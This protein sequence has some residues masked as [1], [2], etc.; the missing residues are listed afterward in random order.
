MTMAINVEQKWDA[1]QYNIKNGNFCNQE[2]TA[3]ISYIVSGTN[4]DAEAMMA[5]YN[6][7]PGQL[8]KNSGDKAGI[9][10]W[11]VQISDRL[12]ETIWK[13]DVG[14][15][16]DTQNSEEDDEEM[17]EMSFEVSG[18]ST[19]VTQAYEQECIYSSVAS[20]KDS[21]SEAEKVPIGWNGKLGEE[22]EVAGVDVPI[23]QFSLSFKKIMSYRKA[24][25]TA[26][27][28]KVAGC[29][30]RINKGRFKG[31]EPG[32]V[33][34]NGAS[35]STP[36]RGADKVSVIFNFIIRLNEDDVKI[37]GHNVGN[38]KGHWYCWAIYDDDPESKGGKK[39]KKVYKARV[40][41]QSD[42]DCLGL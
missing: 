33:M 3:T 27:M 24:T 42:F 8:K 35:Y 11:N 36:M 30:G 10:K 40:N 39:I 41:K 19:H 26:W 9:P 22:S 6:F 17:P 1:I 16:W 20:Q 2:S 15:A 5:A 12:Q 34:F 14:Y 37:G 7:A 31:W 29:Y 23:G 21:K 13:I 28:R 38:V 25:N 4:V 18:G 32:E